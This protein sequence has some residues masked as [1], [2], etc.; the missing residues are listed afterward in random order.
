MSVTEYVPDCSA[1]EPTTRLL[2]DSAKLL[3]FAPVSDNAPDHPAGAT[4]IGQI[5]E[6]AA[7]G[8]V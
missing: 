3:A 8:A 2:A 7:K 6:P 5:T 1:V 4:V